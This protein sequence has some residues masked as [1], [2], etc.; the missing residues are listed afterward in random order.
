MT[1]GGG[2]SE[3]LG[4]TTVGMATVSHTDQKCPYNFP[5]SIFCLPIICVEFFNSNQIAALKSPSPHT[6]L[7]TETLIHMPDRL[8][9]QSK[10]NSQPALCC[11]TWGLPRPPSLLTPVY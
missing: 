2:L 11:H 6:L 10:F 5:M 1:H 8:E 4:M 9:D 7:H 3:G